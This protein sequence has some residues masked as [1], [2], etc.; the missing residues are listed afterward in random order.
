VADASSMLPHLNADLLESQLKKIKS[1]DDY[2]DMQTHH[3]F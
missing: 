2:E 1:R 3:M